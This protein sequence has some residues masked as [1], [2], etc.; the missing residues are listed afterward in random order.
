MIAE[1]KPIKAIRDPAV[2]ATT[3]VYF[4]TI[5]G[6]TV[7]V[8]GRQ[9]IPP[10]WLPITGTAALPAI[11]DVIGVHASLSTGAIVSTQSMPARDLEAY[12]PVNRTPR[13][14]GVPAGSIVLA[15]AV[16]ANLV[17]ALLGPAAGHATAAIVLRVE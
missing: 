4:A 5:Q 12:G 3:S 7:T 11:G 1:G 13:P 15:A 17:A 2:A 16:P 14:P 6:D 9:L 10:V 8:S